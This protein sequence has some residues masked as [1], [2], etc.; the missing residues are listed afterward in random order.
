MTV[1]TWFADSRREVERAFEDEADLFCR[2]LAATSPVSTI[3]TNVAQAIKAY[4]RLHFIGEVT[5]EGFIHTHF[6]SI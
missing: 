3:E 6:V 5:H 2:L 4:Q 1:V